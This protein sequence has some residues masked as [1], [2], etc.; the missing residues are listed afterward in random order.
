MLTTP[1]GL[2]VQQSALLWGEIDQTTD[3]RIRERFVGWVTVKL[4]EVL[5][6]QPWLRLGDLGTGDD[7]AILWIAVDRL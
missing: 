6:G 4:N 7:K 3:D 5:D 1:V 2:L